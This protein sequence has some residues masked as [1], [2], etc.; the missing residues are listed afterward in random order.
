M[1]YQAQKK[2]LRLAVHLCF[3]LMLPT[4]IFAISVF[5]YRDKIHRV[6]Q[7][8][9]SLLSAEESLSPAKNVA[10]QQ[11]VLKA[12]RAKLSPTEKIELEGASFEV[13]NQPFLEKLNQ[14]EKEPNYSP[15][16]A[17]L[18]S[19][20]CEN[21]ST[22]EKKLQELESQNL[23]NRTK[24]EEKQKLAEILK[25]AEYQKPEERKETYLQK[26]WREFWEWFRGAFPKPQM[27]T[28][29]AG[30][31]ESFSTILQVV[32]LTAVLAGIGFLIYRFAPFLV[33]RFKTRE[34]KDKKSR[35][36]LGE[37]LAADENSQNL[38]AEAELLARQGNLRAAVR[39]GYIALLCEL[40]DRKII[41]LARHKT[42]RDYLRDVRNRK[43]LF[44]NMNILTLNFERNWYGFG[45]PEQADW[46][47]FR[48]KYKQ[49]VTDDSMK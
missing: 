2:F 13:N 3:L 47:E 7:S 6:N 32:L 41:G 48:E 49:T 37:T 8:L 1:I 43:E 29:N 5:Q 10:N 39:K 21:L 46:D 25:R 34:K 22:L 27:G 26:L 16:R 18:I 23:S 11:E 31:F 20:V 19:E 9:S 38:F 45:S 28:P 4:A 17:R 14:I 30:A 35:V 36:I 40:S 42:N 24:D 33:N 12:V 15:Q 44:Q